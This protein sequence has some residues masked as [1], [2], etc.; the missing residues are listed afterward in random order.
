MNKRKLKKRFNLTCKE[1][2]IITRNNPR[3]F[4]YAKT[5]LFCVYASNALEK[6][7]FFW[8]GKR[9]DRDDYYHYYERY[10]HDQDKLMQDNI[11]PIS[12]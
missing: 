10:C 1:F 3:L 5:E 12:L 2:K 7:V 4:E 8:K 9:V 11:Q 6:A